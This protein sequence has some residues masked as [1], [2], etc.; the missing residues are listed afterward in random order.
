MTAAIWRR[1]PARSRAGLKRSVIS[2]AERRSL[3]FQIARSSASF[4]GSCKDIQEIKRAVRSVDSR[5]G[6]RRASWISVVEDNPQSAR[7]MPRRWNHS[8]QDSPSHCV[9]ASPIAPLNASS[10]PY[11]RRQCA[12]SPTGG[13]STQTPGARES[14]PIFAGRLVRTFSEVSGSPAG[15]MQF[16]TQMSL[17]ALEREL[18]AKSEFRTYMSGCGFSERCD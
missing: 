9:E 15:R 1:L 16:S 5:I 17:L 4:A 18:K 6:N 14:V 12:D 10:N 3:F 2:C 13:V 11:T 7:V 8:R